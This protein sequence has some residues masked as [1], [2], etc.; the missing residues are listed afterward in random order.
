MS[1]GSSRRRRSILDTP[2]REVPWW[3]HAMALVVV[4]ILM[5]WVV[6]ESAVSH[7]QPSEMA[8][9]AR[10]DINHATQT[11]LESLFGIGPVYAR[12]IIA[13]RP[14]RNAE[15]LSRIRGISP[16]LVERLRAH[17]KAAHGLRAVDLR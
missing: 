13:A 14:F 16:R 12:A 3:W 7:R 15:E 8:D 1:A 5:S 9:P 4:A 2:L 17:I 11:E 10:I 6:G